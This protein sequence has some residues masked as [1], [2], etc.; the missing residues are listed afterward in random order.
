VVIDSD[1]F[2]GKRVDMGV[3]PTI[4]NNNNNNNNN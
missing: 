3:G 1:G 4:L 2:E